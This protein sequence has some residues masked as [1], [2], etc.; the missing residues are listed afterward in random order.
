MNTSLSRKNILVA[1][2]LL[3]TS[4]VAV[5]ASLIGMP[6]PAKADPSFWHRGGY[7]ERDLPRVE[8]NRRYELDHNYRGLYDNRSYGNRGERGDYRWRDY[9]YGRRDYYDRRYYG[10]RDYRNYYD[11]RDYGRGIRVPGLRIR[12]G[13]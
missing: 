7:Y 4:L 9:D 3:A 12:I 2:I 1:P 8:S 5:G 6:Q 13:F 11:Q 10:R